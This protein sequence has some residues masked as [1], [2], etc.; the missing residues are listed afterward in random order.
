M[1]WYDA[2]TDAFKDA[3]NWVKGAATDVFN[4]VVKPVAT[5][6]FEVLKPVVG[7]V[8]Q[9]ASPILG[10]VGQTGGRLINAGGKFAEGTLQNVQ[11]L[12]GGLTNLITSPI[13]WIVAIGAGIIILPKVL[14][15]L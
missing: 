12:Q 13:I 5:G 3:G 2:I 14:D 10:A 4:D 15:R 6:T 11:N 9:A 8:S 1:A 7:A